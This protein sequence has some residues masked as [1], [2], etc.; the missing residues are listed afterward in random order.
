MTRAQNILMF[1]FCAISFLSKAQPNQGKPILLSFT[2]SDWCLP[3]I[4][5]E[6]KVISTVCFQDFASQSLTLENVDFPQKNRGIPKSEINRRDSLA[7]IYNQEGRFPRFILI[8]GNR[9]F[10]S[11]INHMGKDSLQFVHEIQKY[12]PKKHQFKVISQKRKAMG[13]LFQITLNEKDSSFFESCWTELEKT[14]KTISSWDSLSDV[15]MI[16]RNA[17]IRPVKVSK[18]L[19]GLLVYSKAIH[20]ISQG[21]FNPL[22]K[23]LIRVWNWKNGIVPDASQVTAA[24]GLCD[25]DE[26]EISHTDSTVFLAKKGMSIDLGG[27]GKGYAAFQLTNH[28]K[29]LNVR[30]G[31]IDA[32]G[33]IYVFGEQ[34]KWP[35]A[36]I[37]PFNPEET[38]YEFSILQGAVATSG[39]YFRSFTKNNQVY[40]H[41]IDPRT[42][43]PTE[44]ITS[45]SIICENPILADGLATAVTVLGAEAGLYL[46]NQL[47]EVECII[48]ESDQTVHFSSGLIV[49]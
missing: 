13:T 34:E 28:L 17:G 6:R 16:N 39:D 29:R 42:G 18:G 41:I 7:A 4:E 44:G 10:I 48:I 27:I 1:F 38:I 15:G 9:E 26:M 14:E 20:K 33:D 32:G 35:V 25:I 19:F 24:L 46:V 47:K 12:L 5:F 30:E 3:C 23:P 37:N 22:M 2:G 11:E 40:S 45:V 36:V 43:K 49:E 21:S 8:D 31:A